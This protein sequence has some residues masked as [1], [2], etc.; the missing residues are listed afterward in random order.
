MHPTYVARFPPDSSV[1]PHAS[2]VP[3]VPWCVGLLTFTRVRITLLLVI[4]PLSSIFGFASNPD[5]PAPTGAGWKKAERGLA[6]AQLLSPAF[7]PLHE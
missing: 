2:F 1:P 4:K 6:T 5:L 7:S 3:L